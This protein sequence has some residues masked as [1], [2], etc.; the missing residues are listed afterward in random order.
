MNPQ[1]HVWRYLKAKLY[2]PAARSCM[3]E[4]ILDIKNIFDELNSNV[5]KICSLAYARN[6]L[7]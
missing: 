5:D 2:K 3:Q 4:L 1:E 7:V 6:Y